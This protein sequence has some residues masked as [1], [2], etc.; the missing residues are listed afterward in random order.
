MLNIILFL[1][2]IAFIVIFVLASRQPDDFGV[3]RTG[4]I[5]APPSA[6]FPHVNDLHKWE[7]WSPWAKLDPNSKTTFEGPQ[8]GVGTKMSWAGNNK[9][10]VGSMTVIES[11]PNEYIKFKLEFL[12]PMQATNTAEFTFKPE[13][14]NTTVT[15][16]MTGTK[17]FM[18][19]VMSL[20]MD[21]EKM[22]GGQFEKGLADLKTLAES[23]K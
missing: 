6:V 9:V 23:G 12:K 11:R 16:A 18:T 21:C 4:S 14:N 13:G 22:A 5:A 1:I 3:T 7:A 8:E 2:V 15:W 10:G 20:F 19:K 17:N